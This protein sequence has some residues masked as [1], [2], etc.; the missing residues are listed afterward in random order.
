MRSG[1][2]RAIQKLLGHKS[3][4][5]AEIYA[6]FSDKHLHHVVSLLQSP[7]VGIVLGRPTILPGRGITQVVDNKMVGDTGFEPVT[8]T[9]C[10]RHRKKGKRKI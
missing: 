6:H 7:N 9:V 4:K 5:T 2:I 1:N 3:I 10:K 8:S